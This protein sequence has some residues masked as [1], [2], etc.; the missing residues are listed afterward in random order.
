MNPLGIGD[1]VQRHAALAE[2]AQQLLQDTGPTATDMRMY[3]MM[4]T[5][6]AI[7]QAKILMP[8]HVAP[9]QH[10][11]SWVQELMHNLDRHVSVQDDVH[12]KGHCSGG[13]A[14][15]SPR[16]CAR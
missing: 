5:R 13:P 10:D 14:T 12:V 15:Q 16:D 2:Q 3:N 4:C 6:E 11:L 9:V 1:A 8:S 7:A